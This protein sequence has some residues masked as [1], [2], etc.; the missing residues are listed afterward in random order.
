MMPR[1]ATVAEIPNTIGHYA[2]FEIE[3]Y[4]H[5]SRMMQ[6]NH[7][8]FLVKSPL[9][10]LL[11]ACLLVHQ[12]VNYRLVC[13][14]APPRWSGHRAEAVCLDSVKCTTRVIN[15][16]EGTRISSPFCV[17]AHAQEARRAYACKQA[18]RYFS[19]AEKVSKRKILGAAHLRARCTPGQM[20]IAELFKSLLLRPGRVLKSLGS[21][22]FSS[23]L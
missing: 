6:G 8:S 23:M 14:L 1:A 21:F 22:N 20:E 16:N 12:S 10:R 19:N 15:A 2:P 11:P 17:I 18:G 7:S 5:R 13:V 4:E 9:P 3:H